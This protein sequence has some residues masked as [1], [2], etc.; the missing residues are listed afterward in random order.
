MQYQNDAIKEA[1]SQKARRDEENLTIVKISLNFDPKEGDEFKNLLNYIY[2]FLDYAPFIALSNGQYL[3]FMERTKIH[4]AV[5]TLK[6][7]LLSTNITFKDQIKGIGVTTF[8]K[9]EELE[10]SIS[11]ASKLLD[12]SMQT[13]PVQIHY[14]TSSFAYSDKEAMNGLN[15]IF[16]KEP[17]IIVYSFYK[18]APIMQDGQIL[19]YS[20][21]TFIIKLQ[22]EF[23]SFLKRESF[24]YLENELV[25]DIMKTDIIKIDIQNSILHLGEIKFLDDSPVHRKNIRVTPYRPVKCSFGYEDEFISDAIISD[26]SINS[27][28]ATTQLSKIEEIQAKELKNKKFSITFS[29]SEDDTDENQI[30][31]NAKILKITGNQI[32]F[33]TYPDTDAQKMI[34]E[35][36]LK[37]QKI[38]LLEAQG[39]RV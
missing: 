1:L 11:R 34:L 31:I 13:N 32:V 19:E 8:E 30:K 25:P 22:K 10:E 39:I 5:I 27:I 7:M 17:N 38:L 33:S 12:S 20:E 14:A 6:N 28:L 16:V 29:L 15:S 18:E 21:N 37:C 35:Y 24:V 36:I 3:F 23:L 2:S 4:T 9:D 26:I